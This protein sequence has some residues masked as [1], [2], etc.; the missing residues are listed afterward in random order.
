VKAIEIRK[1]QSKK[2]T[3]PMKVIPAL[4]VFVLSAV[5]AIPGAM[6]QAVV[7]KADIPF[8]FTVGDTA[9]PAGEYTVSSPC[10]VCFRSRT[11]IKHVTTSVTTARGYH[12]AGRSSELEF[13]RYGASIS[14]TAS[15]APPPSA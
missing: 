1:P 2:E 3:L 9:M 10:P 8:A 7:L 5:I 11:P 15:F 14:S 6:A 4:A 12:D 13:A